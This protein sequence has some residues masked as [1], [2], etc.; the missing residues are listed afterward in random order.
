VVLYIPLGCL[1]ASALL[2]F[3]SWNVIF[4]KN[5]KYMNNF[6]EH[7]HK[8]DKLA[9]M[10]LK[11]VGKALGISYVDACR[12]LREQDVDVTIE[13]WKTMWA[14]GGEKYNQIDWCP[15]CKSFSLYFDEG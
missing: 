12:R 2:K 9:R 6:Y 13:F 5:G 11:K 14:E 8:T 7:S 3:F 4:W 1:T 15:E 10:T